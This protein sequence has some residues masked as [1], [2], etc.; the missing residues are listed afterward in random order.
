MQ[1]VPADDRAFLRRLACGLLLGV[2][3]SS[4]ACLVY[5]YYCR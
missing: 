2:G 5:A 3:A 4:I 1:D